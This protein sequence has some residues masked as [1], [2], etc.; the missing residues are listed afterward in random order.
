MEE[1][2]EA[3]DGAEEGQ[4]VLLARYSLASQG[5]LS[6]RGQKRTRED[7]APEY[8]KAF[9]LYNKGE[10]RLETLLTELSRDSAAHNVLQ[11]LATKLLL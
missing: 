2:E 8:D 6:R 11:T 7:T 4:E 9:S 3:L 1:R 10:R 5:G